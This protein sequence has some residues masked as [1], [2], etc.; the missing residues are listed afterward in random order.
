MAAKH[1]RDLV[2]KYVKELGGTCEVAKMMNVVPGA[3]SNWITRGQFPSRSYVQ[4]AGQLRTSPP[5]YLWG[6]EGKRRKRA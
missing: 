2:A 6:M 5:A 3:V 4:I 1:R